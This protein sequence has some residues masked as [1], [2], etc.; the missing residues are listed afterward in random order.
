MHTISRAG[1]QHRCTICNETGH[2][3]ATCPM[4]GP[5]ESGPSKARK[6]S[7]AR[8]CPSQAGPSTP[9]PGAPT[10]VNQDPLTQDHVHQ[11]P[12]NED[13]V[14]QE[15]VN[16]VPVNQDHVNEVHVHEDPVNEVPINQDPVIPIPVNQVPVN[17][18]VRVPRRLGVRARKPTE[19]I[20]KI[21]IRK[22]VF[23]KDGKGVSE[24]NPVTLD[25]N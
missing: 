20:N 11:D 8:N 6:K 18:G 24:E 9:A 1:V 5:S 3:K 15:N 4:R 16:E 23:R 14:N 13:P 7:N 21:Q 22:Q 12:V 19:R 17:L 10:H 25:L 2:N